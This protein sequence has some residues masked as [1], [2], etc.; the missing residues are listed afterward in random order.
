MSMWKREQ[1]TPIILSFGDFKDAAMA[2]GGWRINY[3]RPAAS[4][5]FDLARKF[6]PTG[7][8]ESPKRKNL[9]RSLTREYKAKYG[10]SIAIMLVLK[11][12]LPVVIQLL[13][14]WWSRDKERRNEMFEVWR[15]AA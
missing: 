13:I 14:E 12:V 1:D 15:E 6:W 9:K 8:E 11:I 5:L 7:I 10:S 2:R 3:N 4:E